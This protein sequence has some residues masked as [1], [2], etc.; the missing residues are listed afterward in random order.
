[1]SAKTSCHGCK[2]ASGGRWAGWACRKGVPGD[3]DDYSCWE[4][5]SDNKEF[6][7]SR[8]KQVR[9]QLKRK[10]NDKRTN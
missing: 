7:A 1:M 5:D 9:Q 10:D 4:E 2:S 3:D 8:N 6:W